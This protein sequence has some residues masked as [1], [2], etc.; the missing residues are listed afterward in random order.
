MHAAKEKFETLTLNLG[1]GQYAEVRVF[2]RPVKNACIYVRVDG[3]RLVVPENFE[4]DALL[5]LAPRLGWLREKLKKT[6]EARPVMAHGKFL[7]DGEYRSF[8]EGLFK[9]S[10][11]S[12]Y[13]SLTLAFVEEE[14]GK[15]PELK[16]RSI[17]VG[18]SGRWWGRCK[19]GGD[20]EFNLQLAALPLPL[21]QYVVAHELAHLKFMDH[22]AKFKELL[23]RLIPDYRQREKELRFYI[24]MRAT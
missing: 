13:R 2:R 24:P 11:T 21:R 15:Y 9:G 4:G 1:E 10:L 19:R 16:P 23:G 22:S 8:E 20:V 14:I 3:V 7:L 6:S 5:M 12:F 17:G 18:N